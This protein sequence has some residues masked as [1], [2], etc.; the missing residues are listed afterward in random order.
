MLP[1]HVGDVGEGVVQRR[2]ARGA[3]QARRRRPPARRRA[4]PARVGRVADAAVAE[5]FFLE[6]EQGRAVVGAV[7]GI[8][9]RLVDRH[10][11]RL[12]GGIAVEAGMDGDGLAAHAS[13][14]VPAPSLDLAARV[15]DETVLAD[16]TRR[17][18]LAARWQLASALHLPQRGRRLAH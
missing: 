9:R 16:C 4:A 1:P 6:I 17:A 7:E 11:H 10:R 15:V 14:P 8:G 13:S 3:A 2:L 12:G 5:A 18:A